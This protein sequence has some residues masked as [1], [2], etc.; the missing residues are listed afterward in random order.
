MLKKHRKHKKENRTMK[1]NKAVIWGI[2]ILIAGIGLL[3]F[4]FQPQLA[5]FT[6]P[7]WKWIAAALLVYWLIYK[8]VFGRKLTTKL[9]VFIPLALLFM[10]FEKEIGGLIGRGPDFVNN[11]IVILAALLL[12][13]AVYFIFRSK[14]PTENRNSYI[15]FNNGKTIYENG[16]D[17]AGRAWSAEE[18]AKVRTE[19]RSFRLGDNVFYVDASRPSASVSN[20]L[21]SLNVYYQNTDVGDLSSPLELNVTNS[22][23]STVIHIPRNWHVELNEP[24]NSMGSV[25]CRK[26]AEITI[27][28]ITINVTN[29]M[30][31]VEIVSEN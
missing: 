10:I 17:N 14:N 5:I 6:V 4:A 13:I 21:G 29:N 27:R 31:S 7:V 12:N 2:I 9:T 16:R 15:Q 25:D 30:G 19:T 22:L 20:K 23:G 26:D 3:V 8:I 18:S 24:A 1:K 28:T 11:W